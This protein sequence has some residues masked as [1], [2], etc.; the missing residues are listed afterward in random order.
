[1]AEAKLSV[2]GWR[3]REATVCATKLLWSTHTKAT[4]GRYLHYESSTPVVDA[5]IVLL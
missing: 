2:A 3:K 4:N 5:V 1:M